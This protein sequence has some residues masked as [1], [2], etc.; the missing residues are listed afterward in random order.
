MVMLVTYPIS[1]RKKVLNIKE[2]ENLSF[3]EISKRYNLSKTTVFK[4]SKKLE[5]AKKRHRKPRCLIPERNAGQL[6]EI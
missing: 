1:F 4:W 2:K 5:P 3:A 6:H